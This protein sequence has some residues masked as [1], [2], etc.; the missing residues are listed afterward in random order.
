MRNGSCASTGT[1]AV[2]MAGSEAPRCAEVDIGSEVMA[3][4]KMVVR[5]RQLRRRIL[6]D[7][8]FEGPVWDLILDLFI[9]QQEATM[10][11]LTGVGI[12]GSVPTTT[13]LRWIRRLVDL[14]LIVRVPDPTDG[15]RT[16]VELAP[17]T[18]AKVTVYLS[19]VA[20]IDA[21]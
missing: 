6:G 3:T 17:E 4:A 2:P 18:R 13:A 8:L 14:G 10:I 12:A 20:S 11:S 16:L 19:Y 7:G 9:A 21:K 15:R 1:E 5:Q